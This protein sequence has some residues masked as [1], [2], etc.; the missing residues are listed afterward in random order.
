[1]VAAAFDAIRSDVARAL[2]EGRL[3]D[4]NALLQ[5][6]DAAWSPDYWRLRMRLAAARGSGEE[7]EALLQE[8]LARGPPDARLQFE[9]G[10]LGLKLGRRNMAVTAAD[11]ASANVGECDAALLDAVGTLYVHCG[12][13]SKGG[14]LLRR[15]TALDGANPAYWF[16]LA[17]ADRMLGDI[18]A[19]EAALGRVLAA[20][21][22][23][24]A[25][26]Y[27]LSGLRRQTVTE[28]HI[29]SIE[30]A[31]QRM[32]SEPQR[33]TALWFALAKEYEDIGEYAKS[34]TALDRGC[35]LCR[36]GMRY[37]VADDVAA[38]NNIIH[39]F[40]ERAVA[41]TAATRGRAKPIFVVGL[42]RSGTTLVERILDSH[43]A[44][45]GIGESQAFP[46]AA[47][48][49]V[50]RVAGRA[51]SKIEF[52]EYSLKVDPA[53]LADRY[54]AEANSANAL[55]FADKLPLNY[56]YLGLIRRALPD[57]KFVVLDRDPIDV[58]YA[59]YKTLFGE[60]YP[61]SYALEDLAHYYASY[62]R[63][64]DHWEAVLGPTLIRVKYETL[65]L[66]P[67]A[68]VQRLL[69][70]L[71]LRC[72]EGCL[73]FHRASG[74]VSSASAVQVREPIHRRSVGLWRKYANELSPLTQLL[75]ELGVHQSG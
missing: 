57:A 62:R 33:Q 60:A 48:E 20:N 43:S 19:A 27:M 73:E 71:D 29:Q 26:H 1:M 14:A 3:G 46:N 28:N 23:D 16:N 45:T 63:L 34:F 49:G 15:A 64:I 2:S 4:A 5:S 72:E 7:A 6:S 17:A 66:E 42:P 31:I 56:L 11:A 40:D 21:P 50:R 51:V 9:V 59:M 53:F 61:F 10:M 13:E 44:I 38:I 74:A 68:E 30:A 52:A 65:T 70:H 47:I 18:D 35:R 58:C 22:D 25:A 12:E 24:V 39:R 69:R 75:R 55:C 32:K 37:E 36:A 67:E 41:P 8:M 54:L